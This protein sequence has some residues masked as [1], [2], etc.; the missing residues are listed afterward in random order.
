MNGCP[1]REKSI[2]LYVL[3]EL[4]EDR[5]QALAEHFTHCPS[6]RTELRRLET[7]LEKVK[8]AGRTPRL[9]R[10][11]ADAMTRRIL[12]RFDPKLR[13]RG[14]RWLTW[15]KL[16]PS[17]AAACALLLFV[18]IFSYRALDEEKKAPLVSGLQKEQMLSPEEPQTIQD[19]D[20][21]LLM[22]FQTVQKLVRVLDASSTE[23]QQIDNN[24]SV[25]RQ[26]IH[27]L[28]A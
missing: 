12:D 13:L 5:R 20:M 8:T 3:E 17:L 11:S 4:S 19:Q 18:G 7:V 10:Q 27:V 22:E 14:R 25:L 28:E 23:G 1:D 9:P 6:C 16:V 24:D 15:P 2:W 21:E 26:I